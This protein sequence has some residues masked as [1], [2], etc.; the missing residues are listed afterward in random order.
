MPRAAE[1]APGSHIALLSMPRS[2]FKPFPCCHAAVNQAL[3]PSRFTPLH[4]ATSHEHPSAVPQCPVTLQATT[5]RVVGVHA[6]ACGVFIVTPLAVPSTGCSLALP[7]A[8]IPRRHPPNE[9]VERIEPAQAC[10]DCAFDIAL[11]EALPSLEIMCGWGLLGL[12]I[13][14]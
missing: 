4:E 9:G 11:R 8:S 13:S 2:I 1:H 3:L 10:W 6:A 14:A 12:V 7:T 5:C